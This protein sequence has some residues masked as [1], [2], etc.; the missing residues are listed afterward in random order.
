M[1]GNEQERAKLAAQDAWCRLMVEM[2][3]VGSYGTPDLDP[4]SQTVVRIMG[5]WDSLCRAL[6]HAS[7]T[8]RHRD[9]VD[10]YTRYAIHGTPEQRQLTGSA[11]P[12][13]KRLG[14]GMP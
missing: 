14:D 8:F 7:L 5:G 11:S 13:V 4:I 3:R 6:T 1:A 10:L 2:E 12:E 9:F